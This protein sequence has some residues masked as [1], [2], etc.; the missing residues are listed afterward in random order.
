MMKSFKN[1]KITV[2]QSLKSESSKL[3]IKLYE[4]DRD[5]VL[6]GRLDRWPGWAGE[7]FARDKFSANF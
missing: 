5:I 6:A 7:Y 2:P 1:L 4:L 3:Q